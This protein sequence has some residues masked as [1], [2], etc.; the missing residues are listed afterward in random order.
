LCKLAS[1]VIIIIMIT[2]SGGNSP[3]GLSLRDE[4]IPT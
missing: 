3:A 2:N 1:F 4:A